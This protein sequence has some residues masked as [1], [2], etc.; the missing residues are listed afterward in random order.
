MKSR[1]DGL[2]CYQLGRGGEVK[3]PLGWLLDKACSCLGYKVGNVGIHTNHALVLVNYGGATA[4]EIENFAR[5]ISER[6]R[7]KVDIEI[8][9]EVTKMG[10]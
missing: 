8:E 7:L 9:W 5:D 6:V 10:R 1:Y 3:I 4:A 2:P